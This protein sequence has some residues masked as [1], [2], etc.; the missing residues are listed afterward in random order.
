LRK[1]VQIVRR[2]PL[3]GNSDCKFTTFFGNPFRGGDLIFPHGHADASQFGCR[4]PCQS[5]PRTREN[6]MR[7]MKWPLIERKMKR[8]EKT[9]GHFTLLSQKY[10]IFAKN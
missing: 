8:K 2:P 1:F 9:I 10:F 4:Q 7:G 5:H 6:C 3:K